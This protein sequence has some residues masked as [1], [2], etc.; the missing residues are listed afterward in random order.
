[1]ANI[2]TK[3]LTR[4][5]GTRGQ[6]MGTPYVRG[7]KVQHRRR[8][9]CTRTCV[10]VWAC[11]AGACGTALALSQIKN[12]ERQVV[13]AM[14]PGEEPPPTSHQRAGSFTRY[15]RKAFWPLT[16]ISLLVTC[17]LFFPWGYLD[18]K[19][20]SRLR[21]PLFCLFGWLVLRKRRKGWKKLWNCLLFF[22]RNYEWKA[23]SS[24]EDRK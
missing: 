7:Q 9:A 8:E 6:V 5:Q 11:R 13:V 21:K 10:S 1:M 24:Q 17:P 4:P 3:P 20:T 15:R 18:W 22:C 23:K 2:S 19:H 16:T 14:Q 12:V